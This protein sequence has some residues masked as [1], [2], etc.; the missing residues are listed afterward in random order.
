MGA[1]NGKSIS[2]SHFSN[3]YAE[4]STM[5]ERKRINEI[6]QCRSLRSNETLRWAYQNTA[7]NPSTVTFT[8]PSN[9]CWIR[10]TSSTVCRRSLPISSIEGSVDQEPKL[11]WRA[12]KRGEVA[13]LRV[14]RATG[15]QSIPPT[16]QLTP[17]A[18][19]C[20]FGNCEKS[21]DRP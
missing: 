19:S 18:T 14:E 10:A 16:V 9:S 8:T 7:L 13:S 6:K 5:N 20:R 4:G 2:R 3:S 15:I 21:K 12:D 11:S 1:A 17:K